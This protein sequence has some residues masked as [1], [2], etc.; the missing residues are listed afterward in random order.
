[1]SLERLLAYDGQIPRLRAR[2]LREELQFRPN[3]RI[4]VEQMR[5][6]VFAETGDEEQAEE[7]ARRYMAAL[8]RNGETPA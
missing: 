2:R 5:Q 3:V 8:L 6:I 4:T 1:M 7:A